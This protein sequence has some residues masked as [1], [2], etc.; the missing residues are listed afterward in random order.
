ME[1]IIKPQITYMDKMDFKVNRELLD[2]GNVQLYHSVCKH[3]YGSEVDFL[4]TDPN[5]KTTYLVTKGKMAIIMNKNIGFFET[6]I[7]S[8]KFTDHMTKYTK[9]KSRCTLGTKLTDIT[10]T[11]RLPLKLG[12]IKIIGTWE[13]SDNKIVDWLQPELALTTEKKYT[14]FSSGSTNMTQN[15][16]DLFASIA[17][18]NYQIDKDNTL[19]ITEFIMARKPGLLKI[20]SLFKHFVNWIINRYIPKIVLRARNYNIPIV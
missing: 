19:I 14:L 18:T 7:L 1:T 9:I 12:S 6:N 11:R 3:G 17:S 2:N 8:N 10:L 16:G 4:S 13:Y 15:K 20:H 5:D